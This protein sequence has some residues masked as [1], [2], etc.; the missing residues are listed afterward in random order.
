MPSHNL[1]CVGHIFFYLLEMHPK[2]LAKN[3]E[4]TMFFWGVRKFVA[5]EIPQ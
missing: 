1:V 2:S 5:A 3:N 4:L